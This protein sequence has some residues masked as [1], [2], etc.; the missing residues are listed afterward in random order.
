MFILN[1]SFFDLAS[2]LHAAVPF[3]IGYTLGSGDTSR[4]I[5]RTY[6]FICALLVGWEPFELLLAHAGIEAFAESWVNIIGDLCLGIPCSFY[7]L[8]LGR[9]AA[10]RER[11]RLILAL[12][13]AKGTRA[14]SSRA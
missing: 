4:S 10:L 7:G 8:L 9:A 2:L 1:E 11:A 14:R 3:Y 5:A 6:L 12:E 13:R